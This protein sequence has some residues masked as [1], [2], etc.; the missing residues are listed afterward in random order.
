M[1][2]D[3]K[4]VYTNDMGTLGVIYTIGFCCN[5]LE[6]P[7]RNNMPF[8]SCLSAGM[9]LLKPHEST[10]YKKALKIWTLDNEEP[11]GRHNML[12]HVGNFAGDRLKGYESDS[13]GCTLPGYG[14]NPHA[15]QTMITYSKKAMNDLYNLVAAEGMATLVVENLYEIV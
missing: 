5:T 8:H 1:V 7:D 12:F 6:L 11:E 3:L 14:I 13:R 10:K 9:W 15:N 2:L 4:R